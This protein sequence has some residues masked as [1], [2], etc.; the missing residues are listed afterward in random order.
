[1]SKIYGF[2]F[3]HFKCLSST[4]DKAKEIAA[5]GKG[6]TIIVSEKQTK[7]RG[8]FGRK[9]NSDIGGVY[10]TIVL[11][12]HDLDKVSYL[13]FA[14]SISV[15]KSIIGM[16]S[17]DAE[18][19]W[20]NDVIINNKKVCGILAEIMSNKENFALVGIGV[21]VNNSKFPAELK[22]KATSLK[23]QAGK[24]FDLQ[25]LTKRIAK[26]FSLIYRDYANK[27]YEKIIDLWK[28][29]S[30]TLGK[31]VIAHTINGDFIG[32]AVGIDNECRL[33]LRLGN[34]KIKKITEADIFIV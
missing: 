30:H 25:A 29:Y 17:L 3:Y 12:G 11:K 7:G 22:D 26:E 2:N 14:A 33:I 24:T 1:M 32:N 34:G 13:T 27:N 9:W 8:R 10:M 18:V 31:K 16:C 20:P 5:Q 28:K 15:A 19:K 4:N 23:I 21:N 6:N